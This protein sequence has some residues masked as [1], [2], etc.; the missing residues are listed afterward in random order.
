MNNFHFTHCFKPKRQWHHYHDDKALVSEIFQA[1]D[2][3]IKLQEIQAFTNVPAN[4]LS[5]WKKKYEK[6]PKYRPG[7]QYG[8]W[9]RKFTIEQE[10]AVADFLRIQYILPGIVVKRK[11]LRALL[12]ELWKSYDLENRSN[13]NDE[14]SYH[15][16]SDFCERND[17][18]FRKMRKKKRSELDPQE[19][20]K[21]AKKYFKAL[22][23]YP[24]ELI[25]NMDETPWNFVF[26]RGQV[27]AERGKEEVDAQLPDDYR[28]SFTV[29]AT[30][31]NAG[32]KHPPVFLA[33]G[34][35]ASCHQQFADMKTESCQYELWHSIGGNTNEECMLHYLQLVKS[36][37][38][39][40]SCALLLD[41]YKAHITPKVKNEA[42]QLD[43]KL[44]Y[45]PTSG[46]DIYQPL[47]KK[48]FGVLKSMGQSSFD[49]FLW[50]NFRGLSKSEA[51]DLFM[52][53]WKRLS[54]IVI[55]DSWK[56]EST[57]SSDYSSDDE[58]ESSSESW[59]IKDEEDRDDPE[60]ISLSLE[61]S[62]DTF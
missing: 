46:T 7:E 25:L 58:N 23:K 60:P 5:K 41:R 56:F 57:D 19:I 4:L 13:I 48:V 3:G 29:I 32:T 45:I 50:D 43:I 53:C 8:V 9:R 49:N 31:T 35:T 36:W 17:L 26:M 18:S 2:M 62:K 6:D 22:N 38:K 59:E 61:G 55:I 54:S 24:P 28:K 51:A 27:L 39:D 16:V 20:Q 33:K 34:K 10:Q 47:D 30:I 11:H 14:F 52:S 40:Q 42:K 15:F 12:F 37:V 21:F 44:I 1:F